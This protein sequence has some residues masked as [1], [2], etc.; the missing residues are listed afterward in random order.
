[1]MSNTKQISIR[2][3]V[4]NINIDRTDKHIRI[5]TYNIL[6]DSLLSCSTQIEKEEL[7]KYP[8]LDWETRKKSILQ[9]LTE[10]NGDLVCIQEFEKDESFIKYM[11]QNGYDVIIV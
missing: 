10:L 7:S 11:G 6:C 1:M 4:P 9:E 8:F 3:W 2:H 5:L